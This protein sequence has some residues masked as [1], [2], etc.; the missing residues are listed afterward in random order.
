MAHVRGPP[1]NESAYAAVGDADGTYSDSSVSSSSSL[2]AAVAGLHS[3][4]SQREGERQQQLQQGY[5][6]LYPVEA[7]RLRGHIDAVMAGM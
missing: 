5:V 4:P 2:S 1:R 7:A 3:S 6:T